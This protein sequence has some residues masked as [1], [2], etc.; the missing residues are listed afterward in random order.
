MNV[1]GID[2]GGTGIKGAPVNVET[3]ELLAERFRIPT[4]HP[5]RPDAVADVVAEITRH[6]N[7]AGPT[8]ITFPAIIKKG[9]VYSASNVDTSWI[10][11]DAAAL[12][13]R[14]L[15]G[16]VTVV[17]DADAAGIAE[18]R[19]GAGR[20]Q[21]GVVILL[22]FGTG[23]GSAIFYDGR[24]LPNSEFGHLTIRGKDAEKR[25]SEKVREEKGLSWKQWAGRVSEYLASLEKLFSPDL[26][27]IGGGVSN[28]AEKFLS[29]LTAGTSVPVEAARMRN[30]AGIIGAAC[31]AA[32][33]LS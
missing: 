7:H 23:I 33:H 8:G 3:G 16:P 10:G 4:P 25:S 26:F 15:G 18:M 11:T 21:K 6:F 17:N 24:L 12:F 27:I 30:E 9:G 28:K 32:P 22:T 29:L 2:I 1:L 5:A 13:T 31:V 19:F 20:G 14:R